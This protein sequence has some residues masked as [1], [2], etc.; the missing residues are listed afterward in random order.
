MSEVQHLLI[1]ASTILALLQTGCLNP[2]RHQ[3]DPS[4]AWPW[5]DL[6][7]ELCCFTVRA[8]QKWVS[9]TAF[10][11]ICLK[12]YQDKSCCCKQFSNNECLTNLSPHTKC[13]NTAHLLNCRG[14]VLPPSLT[15]PGM[16]L[17][18]LHCLCKT[19]H[20]LFFCPSAIFSLTGY[21]KRH[22][23]KRR[24]SCW[25]LHPAFS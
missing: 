3:T 17:A 13:P 20:L 14:N 2:C 10:R 24:L 21:R 16:F 8:T 22:H 5:E 23:T 11:N 9:K 25:K 1:I 7:Q 18:W 6:R 15:L 19:W 12:I 4:K